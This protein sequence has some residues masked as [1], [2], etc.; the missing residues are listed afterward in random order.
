MFHLRFAEVVQMRLPAHVVFQI[1]RHMF[2][3]QNVTGIAAIHH[4]LRHV[5]ARARDVGPPVHI[6]HFADRSAMNAHPHL[7]RRVLL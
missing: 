1:V 7:D 2:G 6:G 5:N 3:K 4:S